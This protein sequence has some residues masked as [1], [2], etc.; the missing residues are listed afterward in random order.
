MD[1]HPPV[2]DAGGK[3]PVEVETE[4]LFQRVQE[5]GSEPHVVVARAPV[6]LPRFAALRGCRVV[7][8][9]RGAG[10]PLGSRRGVA[11]Q[12]V[13]RG[14]VL[15]VDLESRCLGVD[16]RVPVLVPVSAEGRAP[17]L[18]LLRAS[19]VAVKDQDQGHGRAPVVALGQVQPVF[20][21]QAPDIEGQ[22]RRHARGCWR[23]GP[24]PGARAHGMV[25]AGCG[26]RGSGQRAPDCG[27]EATDTGSVQHGRSS[28]PAIVPHT[29]C[30]RR[31][32]V[33]YTGFED[34]SQTTG[35]AL[36]PCTVEAVALASRGQ[37]DLG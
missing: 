14:D 1:E 31:D 23:P 27:D 34:L 5:G 19:G 13:P 15:A 6:A 18:R 35:A 11:R 16:H 2:A 12:V 36:T 26:C 7:P 22:G 33:L 32:V 20:P 17:V 4:G 24:A 30:R 28:S 8:G 10:Q 25:D 3:D 21:S 37:G 9:L 29:P